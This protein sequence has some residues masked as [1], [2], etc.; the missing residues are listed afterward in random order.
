MGAG[1]SPTTAPW[2]DEAR[3]AGA[4]S[5][6]VTVGVVIAVITAGLALAGMA[7]GLLG[8]DPDPAI[9][10]DTLATVTTPPPSLKQVGTGAFVHESRAA[11]RF[12]RNVEPAL[13][14]RGHDGPRALAGHIPLDGS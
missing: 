4:A 2:R 9:G 11:R 8:P 3:T 12:A 7:G 5:R 14:A 6:I 1:P 10:I 13:R